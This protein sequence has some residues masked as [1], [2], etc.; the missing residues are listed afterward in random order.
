[1]PPDL[2]CK[3]SAFLLS[4]STY[5]VAVFFACAA[6]PAGYIFICNDMR[7]DSFVFIQLPK[8][9]HFTPD[10]ID[11]SRVRQRVAMNDLQMVFGVN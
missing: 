6:S 5:V 3:F 4:S 9:R 2:K 1:L 10:S 11:S 8:S 7:G